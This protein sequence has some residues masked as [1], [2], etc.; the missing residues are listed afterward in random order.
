MTISLRLCTYRIR[1]NTGMR[2]FKPW[3][4]ESWILRRMGVM[5]LEFKL[6]LE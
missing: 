1:S 3:E 4:E 2:M 5:Q 6:G